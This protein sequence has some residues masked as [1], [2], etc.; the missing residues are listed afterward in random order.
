M[1]KLHDQL[2]KRSWTLIMSGG[3]RG[4]AKMV[5]SAL[6]PVSPNPRHETVSRVRER[7]FRL[8]AAEEPSR[9]TD[10]QIEKLIARSRRCERG[11]DLSVIG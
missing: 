8:P 5:S 7:P 3:F 6:N 2:T 11:T 4:T 9:G 1:T 10:R